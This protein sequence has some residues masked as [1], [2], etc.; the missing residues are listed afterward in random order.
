VT[1]PLSSDPLPG[2]PLPGAPLSDAPS[3]RPPS[4]LRRLLP[5]AA[6]VAV[7][8]TL[9]GL[10]FARLDW[11]DLLARYANLHFG[12]LALA[13]GL[14]LV[15]TLLS[16]LKWRVILGADRHLGGA[17][18]RLRYL[19][20]T[21]LIGNFLSLFLP[22]TIGGDFYRVA[23]LRGGGRDLAAGASSVLF[24]RVS[25]VF[26]L[27]TIG[28]VA[29]L[30]LPENPYGPLLVVGYVAGVV[31][32][33]LATTAQVV[34][35]A[36]TWRF[37]PLRMFAKLLRSFRAYRADLA[38]MG[39]ILGIALGFQLNIVLLNKIYGLALGMDLPLSRLAVIVPIIY[40]SEAL[41][42]SINGLG[43]RESAFAYFFP[44]IGRTA[45]DG[46]AISL[47]VVVLRYLMGLLGGGLLLLDTLRRQPTVPHDA[48]TASG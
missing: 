10:L 29:A 35:W 25:G 16:S 27:V 20:K 21:Y 19:W 48:P 39:A 15:Q 18:P 17:Q 22:S 5:T 32:F 43:V 44:L 47:L 4:R 26:A 3:V 38:T 45:A 24:D 2:D 37:R 28:F 30:F 33:W 36:L 34:D 8:V 11:R 23:A 14:L 1:D 42:I 46:V 31:G 13:L 9:L 6:K 12:W 41:P 7:S 40:L